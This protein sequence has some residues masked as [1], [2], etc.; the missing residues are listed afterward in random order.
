[1]SAA[2]HTPLHDR[3]LAVEVGDQGEQALEPA[4]GRLGQRELAQETSSSRAEELGPPVLDFLAG[5]QGVDAVLERGAKTGQPDVVARE[6][7][8]L[9]KRDG[10]DTFAA[11]ERLYHLFGL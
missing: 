4:T 11:R 10:R 2:R 5:K 9:D 7:S 8:R 1:M 3:E 6:L